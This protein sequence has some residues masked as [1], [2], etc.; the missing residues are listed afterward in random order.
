MVRPV[1]PELVEDEAKG[2]F[3]AEMR[4]GRDPVDSHLGGEG[5]FVLR[6]GQSRP[7]DVSSFEDF[8]P[9]VLLNDGFDKS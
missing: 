7:E 3:V 6:K 5:H 1:L 8:D 9:V 2:A 4:H